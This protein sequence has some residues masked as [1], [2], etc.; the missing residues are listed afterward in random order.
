MTNTHDI[1]LQ[2][3][4]NNTCRNRSRKCWSEMWYT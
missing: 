4:W 3:C 1:S 2:I